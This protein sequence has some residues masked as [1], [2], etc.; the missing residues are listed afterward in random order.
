MNQISNKTEGVLFYLTHNVSISTDLSVFICVHL[1]SSAD[2]DCVGLFL[3][4][5]T[6]NKMAS[7]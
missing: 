1:R 4:G 7:S 2:A 6:R 3:E 5:G